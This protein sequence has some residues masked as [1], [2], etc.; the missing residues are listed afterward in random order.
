ME[1]KEEKERER[2]RVQQPFGA[3][4]RLK[5]S[6]LEPGRVPDVFTQVFAT[7]DQSASVSLWQKW[8]MHHCKVPLQSITENRVNILGAAVSL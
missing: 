5:I 8:K 3:A 4:G 1:W 7:R 2:E 6:R